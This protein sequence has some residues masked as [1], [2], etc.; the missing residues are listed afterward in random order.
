MKTSGLPGSGSEPSKPTTSAPRP[1]RHAY[2]SPDARST[3]SLAL[4]D[5]GCIAATP[6]SAITCALIAEGVTIRAVQMDIGLPASYWAVRDSGDD[7]DV[8]DVTLP[9]IIDFVQ[10][11]DAARVHLYTPVAPHATAFSG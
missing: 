3:G 4:S 8:D 6:R 5:K 10:D 11:P 7:P 2:G 1:A 9:L